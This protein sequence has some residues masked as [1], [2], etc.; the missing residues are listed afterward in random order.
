MEWKYTV[1][2]SLRR[3]AGAWSGF[4][5]ELDAASDNPCSPESRRSEPISG[6]SASGL[7]SPVVESS[8]R[9]GAASK[10]DDS[11]AGSQASLIPHLPAVAGLRAA[12]RNMFARD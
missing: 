8:N 10:D 7:P 9:P 1:L 3:N 12:M 2:S 6:E 11:R 4:P 5:S